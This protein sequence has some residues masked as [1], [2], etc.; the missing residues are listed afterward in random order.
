MLERGYTE[1]DLNLRGL[2]VVSTFE[3]QAQT[4]MVMV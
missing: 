1:D 4:G 2:R 3:E